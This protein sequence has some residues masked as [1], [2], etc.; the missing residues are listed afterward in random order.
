MSAPAPQDTIAK[1]LEIL[2]TAVKIGLGA[3]VAGVSGFLLAKTQHRRDLDNEALR[4][5]WDTLE[6]IAAEF[7]KVN[8][9]A[10]R[11]IS[12]KQTSF[13]MSKS[14]PNAIAVGQKLL[15]NDLRVFTE[16]VEAMHK[17][18]GRLLLLNLMDCA[19]D[20]QRYRCKWAESQGLDSSPNLTYEKLE[21]IYAELQD[22]RQKVYDRLSK[23]Y[24]QPA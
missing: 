15:R 7:E 1:L 10:T 17:I 3:I 9:V 4:R 11:W 8:T 13:E 12:T 16:S 22:I 2:D 20:F 18:E 19:M 6:W 23:A 5:R 21:S 14:D 24:S